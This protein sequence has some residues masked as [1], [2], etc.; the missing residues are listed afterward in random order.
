MEARQR[1]FHNLLGGA[2]NVPCPA[3]ITKTFPTA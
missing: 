3:V 1:I 2:M